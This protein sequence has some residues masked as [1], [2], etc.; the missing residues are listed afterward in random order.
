MQ[1]DDFIFR[2]ICHPPKHCS[3]YAALIIIDLAAGHGA[4]YEDGEAYR[5]TAK[6]FY[7][8][9]DDADDPT[10]FIFEIEGE[11]PD[12]K[13]ALPLVSPVLPAGFEP[14]LAYSRNGDGCQHINYFE[15]Y[16]HIC[17]EQDWLL[18]VQTLS[19]LPEMTQ[20]ALGSRWINYGRE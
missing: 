7:G 5:V 4:G 16:E 9:I 14:V 10:E 19:L 2:L 1:K 13:I 11:R 20:E 3:L 6:V 15:G 8:T 17:D 12:L 18:I